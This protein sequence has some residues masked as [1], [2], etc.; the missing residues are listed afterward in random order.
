MVAIAELHAV[1][2]VEVELRKVVV[3]VFLAAVLIDALQVKQSGAA[4]RA[5]RMNVPRTYF[6]ALCVTV[7]WAQIP[8][9]LP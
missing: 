6:L 8:R 1:T 4:F 7:S 9:R 5:I 2:K 3:Q